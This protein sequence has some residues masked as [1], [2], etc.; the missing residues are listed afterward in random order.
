MCVCVVICRHRVKACFWS[1][2][3]HMALS[4]CINQLKAEQPEEKLSLPWVH[5]AYQHFRSRL[6]NFSRILTIC[7]QIPQALFSPEAL[8]DYGSG[9]ELVWPPDGDSQCLQPRPGLPCLGGRLL[10]GPP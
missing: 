4:S 1:Q 5:L 2:V 7:P 3:L 6:Q 8:H 10:P 9:H